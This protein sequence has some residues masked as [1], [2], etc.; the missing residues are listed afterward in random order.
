MTAA[1]H[2]VVACYDGPDSAHAVQLGGMLAAAVG[3]PLVVATAFRYEPSALGAQVAPQSG[4]ERR[5]DVAEGRVRHAARLVGDGV[6]VRERVL[7]AEGIAPAL[8]DLARE[9]DACALVLGR[10]RHGMTLRSVLEHAPCPVAVSPWDV[11]LPG[12]EPLRTIGVAYDGSPGARFALAAAV[13]LAAPAGARVRLVV[14]GGRTNDAQAA[15]DAA[16]PFAL[17]ADVFRTHGDPGERLVEASNDL[18]LLLCGSHGRGRIL[19]SML[20]SVSGRLVREAHC[21]VLVVGLRIRLRAAAPL[22]LTTAAG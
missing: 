5:F 16:R 6:E 17:R 12:D 20:G 3:Q 8:I 15:A 19:A 4:N 18:D 9:A 2:P 22:G 1:E 21:P 7:P 13:H 14:V 11:P 10:D